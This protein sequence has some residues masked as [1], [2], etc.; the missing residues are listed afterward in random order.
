MNYDIRLAKDADHPVN[1]RKYL[2]SPLF[3]GAP[4]VKQEAR[5]HL[6]FV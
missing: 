3:F 5:T 2:Y 6:S 1:N 4:T